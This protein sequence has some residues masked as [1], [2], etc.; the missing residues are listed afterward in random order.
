MRYTTCLSFPVQ[1]VSRLRGCRRRTSEAQ[2]REV[3]RVKWQ[4]MT[5]G[6]EEG[7]MAH[8]SMESRFHIAECY[9]STHAELPAQAK[10]K[11]ESLRLIFVLR[12]WYGKYKSRWIASTRRSS[13]FP[14]FTGFR[15]SLHCKTTLP[16]P[17]RHLIRKADV[18]MVK[19]REGKGKSYSSQR[20]SL[21]FWP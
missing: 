10:I 21:T 7:M 20:F 17:P 14:F 15:A 9:L 5:S 11:L 18:T 12:I 8:W 16:A 2:R 19:Y 1:C 13:W 6:A 4:G 3:G